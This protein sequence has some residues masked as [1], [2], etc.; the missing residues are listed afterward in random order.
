[1]SLGFMTCEKQ[2][3]EL[4]LPL[5][6]ALLWDASRVWFPRNRGTTM[7]PSSKACTLN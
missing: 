6:G 3:H 2:P 5:L 7:Q 4:A 1:M